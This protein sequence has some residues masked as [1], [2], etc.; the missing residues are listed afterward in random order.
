MPD[1]VFEIGTEEVPAS[2][3]VPALEQL[4]T[5]VG[6]LLTRERIAH[7]EVRSVGT[8]RRLVTYVTDVAPRQEDAVAEHRGPTKSVA[9][10]ASGSPTKAAEGFARRYG[11]TAADLTV[12][13][14]DGG[15]YV[16]ARQ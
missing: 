11:L 5:L 13:Q 12:R 2:A 14:T 7:G 16:Y 10:A 15:E 1:F 8:P 9:F 6:E 4:R 3:V